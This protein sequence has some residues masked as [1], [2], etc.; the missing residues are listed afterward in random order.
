MQHHH[1]D[2]QPQRYA[3]PSM[4]VP[5]PIGMEE[6]SWE[7][8]GVTRASSRT[9]G[10][11][12]GSLSCTEPYSLLLDT[13]PRPKWTASPQ[14]GPWDSGTLPR[15]E[16]GGSGGKPNSALVP[17][18]MCPGHSFYPLLRTWG[19]S[20]QHQVGGQVWRSKDP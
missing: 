16:P 6:D 4:T 18:L 7:I 11:K 5:Q 14:E 8:L 9:C 2:T 13:R 10:S 17:E 1:R 20:G 15:T 12:V 3:E 19:S